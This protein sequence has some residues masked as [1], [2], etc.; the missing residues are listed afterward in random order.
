MQTQLMIATGGWRLR[1]VAYDTA[2][3]GREVHWCSPLHWWLT[4][5]AWVDHVVTGRSWLV[6]V[7]HATPGAGASGDLAAAHA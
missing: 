3:D 5:V 6:A 1:R 7:E 4:A 2:P